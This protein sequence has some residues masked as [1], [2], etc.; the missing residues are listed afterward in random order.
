MLLSRRFFREKRNKPLRYL[1]SFLFYLI[2]PILFVRL[3]WRS[4]KNPN[5]RSRWLE[6]IGYCPYIFNQCI[7]I[8][9]VSVGESIAAIPFIKAIK[10]RY[11]D[12]PILI[13]NMTP[14]GAARIKA[15]LGDTVMQAYIPYDLPDAVERFLS[16]VNPTVAIVM[17]TEMW[18][19]MFAECKN[20]GIPLMI[21][22]AR[23]SEKSARGYHRIASMT[24]EMLS[25]VSMIAV[26]ASADAERFIALGIPPERIVVTGNLKFDLEIPQDLAAKSAALRTQLGDD[27][28]IW[29]AA[30][31]HQGEEEIILA[32]HR[33]VCK[34]FPNALLILVP[35]H[36]ERFAAMS[37]LAT[38]QGF[39]VARRSENQLCTSETDVYLGDTMG[40]LLLM[41]SVADVTFVAGSFVEVGGHNMLEPAALGKPILT[42]PSLF[43]FAEI[44]EMLFAAQAML[45]V[46]NANQ[47]ADAVIKLLDQP[48]FR[49][50]MGEQAL[51][52]IVANR[53]SLAKQLQLAMNLF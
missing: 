18:P 43:N 27:R 50:K 34:K 20:R 24:Q 48:E 32:A 35:R 19:N 21:A 30:S 37:E 25:A 47:L 26:Q 16:R 51:G 39:R 41:Y 45:K 46:E 44:S 28:L 23:L 11:P 49:K 1:Y 17:E 42:G 29:I 36:P 5:Y 14:T 9:A 2:V 7:W 12:L 22:N 13:T 31:T 53:G 6:R 38:Q 40:E 15:A 10:K 3:L 52:V 33:L 4:R 8:H